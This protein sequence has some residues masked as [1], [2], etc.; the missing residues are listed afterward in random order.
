M[1]KRAFFVYLLFILFTSAA[2]A[3]SPYLSVRLVMDTAGKSSARYIIHMKRCSLKKPTLRNDWFSF[4]KS[5]V[6]FESLPPSGIQCDSYME[7]G[8]GL[9]YLSGDPGLSP[10]NEYEYSNQVFAYESILIFRIVDSSAKEASSMYVVFPIKYKSFVTS[11]FIAGV[12]FQPGSVIYVEEATI[13]SSSRLRLSA[14][15]K[16]IKSTALKDFRWKE[17]L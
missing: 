11:V 5:K 6:N 2:L 17:L 13:G 7:N 16:G 15:L 4:E 9:E 1:K 10:F 3:Q 14:S 12:P 8:G